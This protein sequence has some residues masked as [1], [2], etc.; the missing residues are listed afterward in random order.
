LE[1]HRERR[2]KRFFLGIPVGE[3]S[4]GGRRELF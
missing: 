3:R 1:K 4:L 2:E